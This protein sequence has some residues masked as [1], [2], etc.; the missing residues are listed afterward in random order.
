MVIV[1][2]VLKS[3]DLTTFD[4]SAG[5]RMSEATVSVITAYCLTPSIFV[6]KMAEFSIPTVIILVVLAN[7]CHGE[8]FF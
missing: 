3:T 6:L 4:V 1:A 5:F 7:C 8:N 2:Q